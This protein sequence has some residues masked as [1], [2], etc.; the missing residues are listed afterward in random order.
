VNQLQREG[1][2]LVNQTV[3]LEDQIAANLQTQKT[4]EKGTASTSQGASK[5]TVTIREKEMQLAQLQNELARVK[6]DYQNTVA[7]NTRMR[8]TL[9]EL[10]NGLKEKDQLVER[11]D[12]EIRRRNDEI[13][14]K[15]SEVDRLNK[16]YDQL[17]SNLK[18]ENM[19]P[20]EATIHNLTNEISAKAR[21]CSE[22]QYYWLRSQTEL[23]NLNKEIEKQ[24][25]VIQDM[26][27]QVTVLSQKQLRIQGS[28]EVNDKDI[29][30]LEGSIRN[31]QLDM[32]R[33]NVLI[34]KNN[35]LQSMLAEGNLGLENEFYSQLKV[36]V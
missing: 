36:K 19:G 28:F 33:L 27:R 2:L 31:L 12:L 26:E 5:L 34:S 21:A 3:T 13:E 32:E 35:K 24:A 6:V 7:Q 11:Y 1:D 20:L 4:L 14:R 22:L 8:D 10:L 25:E 9:A 15:Q 29:R 30:E 17:V 16:K 23:V 18:D